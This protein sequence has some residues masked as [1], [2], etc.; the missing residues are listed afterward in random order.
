MNWGLLARW[1]SGPQIPF[2]VQVRYH[3][4]GHFTWGHNVFSLLFQGYLWI[5][6]EE[7]NLDTNNMSNTGETNFYTNWCA[8]AMQ[9]DFKSQ[10]TSKQHHILRHSSNSMF[11]QNKCHVNWGFFLRRKKRISL[12]LLLTSQENSNNKY[13]HKCEDMKSQPW[14]TLKWK[15]SISLWLLH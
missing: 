7:P 11:D 10:V 8:K 14:H 6:T 4:F 12:V 15:V 5:I 9:N 13:G 2:L 3:S 1:L